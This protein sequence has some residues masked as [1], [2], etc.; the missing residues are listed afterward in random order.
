M[1]LL[2]RN[3]SREGLA[4]TALEGEGEGNALLLASLLGDGD[5]LKALLLP[6]EACAFECAKDGDAEGAGKGPVLLS[7]GFAPARRLW[8]LFG[9]DA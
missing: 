1:S 7:Y 2:A 4:L 6:S 5:G 3:S 9:G 8:P